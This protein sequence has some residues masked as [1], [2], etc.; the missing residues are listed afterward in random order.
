L[1]R[2]CVV[3]VDRVGEAADVAADVAGELGS[4]AR[5]HAAGEV[6]E[7]AVRVPE[8]GAAI[9]VDGAAHGEE[10]E[11]GL[12][13]EERGL[14]EAVDGE[15]LAGE[16]EGADERRVAGGD[17]V[18]F[19]SAAELLAIEEDVAERVAGGGLAERLHSERP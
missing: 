16:K 13:V 10:E 18:G 7:L 6:V 5:R 14:D 9:A 17:A 19:A 11:A 4:G 3:D 8:I 1:Q 15:R 2:A 12:H